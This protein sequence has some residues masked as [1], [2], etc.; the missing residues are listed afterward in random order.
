[1]LSA[2]DANIAARTIELSPKTI[3][4]ICSTVALYASPVIEERP[5][6]RITINDWYAIQEL[7]TARKI[8]NRSI[9]KYFQYLSRIISWGINNVEEL[10][11]MAHPWASREPLKAKKFKIDLFSLEDLRKILVHAPDH[12]KWAIEVEY[13]IGMRPGK[14]ELFNLKWEDIDFATGAVSIYASKTDSH[15]HTP[16]TSQKSSWAF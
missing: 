6:H 7:M 14:T 10:R 2:V 3:D 12:L 13:H 16:N 1:M 15:H 9:N 5:C 4:E 11:A 8:S